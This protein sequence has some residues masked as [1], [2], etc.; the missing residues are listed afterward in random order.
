[1]LCART[2]RGLT[3]EKPGQ[4]ALSRLVAN[5]GRGDSHVV[6][7]RL[8]EDEPEGDWYMQVRLRENNTYQLEFRDGIAAEHYQTITVSQEKVIVALTAWAAGRSGWREAF[9]WTNIGSSFTTNEVAAQPGE[10][11]DRSSG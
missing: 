1:M 10:A 6:V 8:G 5:L 4:T 3:V 11:A 7:E 9:M 2:E